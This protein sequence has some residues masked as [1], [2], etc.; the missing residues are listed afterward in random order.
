MVDVVFG[1]DSTSEIVEDWMY[2]KISEKY[3]ENRENR[4]WIKEN[5]PHAMLNITERL[6]EAEKRGMWN[7]SSEKLKELRKIYLEIEGDV[8][9]I[10]E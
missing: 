4:E 9:E 2:D 5:N 6:L 7:I 1:W 3:V 8:E 10:E